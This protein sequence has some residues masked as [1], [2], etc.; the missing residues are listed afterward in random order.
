ML[1][2]SYVIFWLKDQWMI[3]RLSKATGAGLVCNNFTP[4][5]SKISFHMGIKSNLLNVSFRPEPKT[6]LALGL[7]RYSKSCS[8]FSS[9]EQVAASSDCS[10]IRNTLS[11]PV[12]LLTHPT[13]PST[14]E[15][16]PKRLA[17]DS[18]SKPSITFWNRL[19]RDCQLIGRGSNL[20]SNWNSATWPTSCKG[21][22]A[23]E[24]TAQNVWSLNSF[25]VVYL[26]HI[27]AK[28][29]NVSNVH[30]PD[31]SQSISTSLRTTTEHYIWK[32]TMLN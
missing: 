27:W 8:T 19:Q 18:P 4:I 31:W 6:F 9:S 7:S 29:S 5:P 10:R 30:A 11:H 28:C 2:C 20:E 24:T 17:V 22:I 25:Y 23:S 32:A 1:L 12:F 16:C 26:C 3:K 14:P 21:F 15:S 13:R